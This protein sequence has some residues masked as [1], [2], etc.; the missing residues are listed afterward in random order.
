MDISERIKQRMADLDI[1]GVDISRET[2][3][4]SGG[5]SQW[6]NGVSRPGSKYLAPLAKVL[7][8]DPG[9]LLTGREASPNTNP[10]PEF[11]IAPVR[12]HRDSWLDEPSEDIIIPHF[13]EDEV[14][15]EHHSIQNY[16]SAGP[17]VR[18]HKDLI[19]SS[20][21]SPANAIAVTVTGNSM[22]PVL[23]DG[24]IIGIDTGSHGI[25]DGKMYAIEHGSMLRVKVLYR[26]PGGG[27]RLKSYN[28]VEY[29]EESLS[30]EEARSIQIIGRVFWS[31]QTH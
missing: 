6:V 20:C 29:P 11:P 14:A 30:A 3:A 12:G 27:L 8:C 7:Q 25:R 18:I 26:T 22:E 13:Y 15:A 21:T 17:F 23:Q 5:I 31:S 9:W 16:E 1:K 2:G 4:S 28:E 10:K 19:S 24:C